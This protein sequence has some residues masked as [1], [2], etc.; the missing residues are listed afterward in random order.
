MAEPEQSSGWAQLLC[1]PFALAVAPFLSCRE[2]FELSACSRALLRLR[3][4]LGRW[5]FPLNGGTYETFRIKRHS[6]P[7]CFD[8]MAS[9]DLVSHLG[10]RLRIKAI[11]VTNVDAFADVHTLDVHTVLVL[12]M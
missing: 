6:V 1:S 4:D 9:F 8:G 2:I 12:Q 7:P 3:F 11:G 5:D 10:P